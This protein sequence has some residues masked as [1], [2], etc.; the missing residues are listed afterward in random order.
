M[1]RGG[2]RNGAGRRATKL[3]RVGNLPKATAEEILAAH[4]ENAL[5]DEQLT[6]TQTVVTK[7]GEAL[8]FPDFTARRAALIYLTDRRDG[9]AP[10]GV[11]HSGEIVVTV[12]RIGGVSAPGNSPSA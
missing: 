8:S 10:Q 7:Q 6:A 2:K 12:R 1:P 9:K 4:D 3:S 5:W 11:S